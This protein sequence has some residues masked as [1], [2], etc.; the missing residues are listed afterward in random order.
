VQRIH[1]VVKVEDKS[2]VEELEVDIGMVVSQVAELEVDIGKG[3]LQVAGSGTVVRL[4]G[5]HRALQEEED[6]Q[7]ATPE[8][9]EGLV[10]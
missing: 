10:E 9:G 1:F 3:V 2:M 5:E 7:D 8:E 4:E 6:I